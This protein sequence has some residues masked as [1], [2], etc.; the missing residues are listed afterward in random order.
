MTTEIE[1]SDRL[2]RDRPM[3]G[4][5]DDVSYHS[6]V[7]VTS[8]RFKGRIGYVDDLDSEEP[9]R[10]VVYFGLFSLTPHFHSLLERCLVPA[11]TPDLLE[12]HETIRRRIKLQLGSEEDQSDLLLELNL[13]LE[14]LFNRMQEA[15]LNR[16]GFG[17][18][19]FLSHS[20][21]DKEFVKWIAVDL[22]NA[23]HLPWLDEWEIR[24]G[25]SIPTR[26]SEG[27]EQAD[28]VAVVLSNNAVA[29]RW[30][31]R[32][33][34]AKYW[35]ELSEHRIMVLPILYQDC[36]IPTL[37]ATKKYADFRSDYRSGLKQLLSALK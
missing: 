20:S 30:V 6:I 36:R 32:E 15:Q 25:E 4:E 14:S 35:R 31:E 12:R 37:L 9:P 3:S 8:G 5:Y 16:I 17:K 7:K 21:K 23:G 13:I 10:W 22:G 34:Q 19:V 24:V 27:I 2:Q 29:S 28:A 18:R 1:T 26:V 11:T 33:W